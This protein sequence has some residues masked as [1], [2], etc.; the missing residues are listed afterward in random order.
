MTSKYVGNGG[1]WWQEYGRCQQ[2]DGADVAA[3]LSQKR[4][5]LKR[6]VHEPLEVKSVEDGLD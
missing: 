6:P 5:C 1:E 2:V 4:M 3:L